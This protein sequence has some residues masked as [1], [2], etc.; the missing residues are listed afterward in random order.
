MRR[1]CGGSI[2][3]AASG[4][5]MGTA[6]MVALDDTRVPPTLYNTAVCLA[7][8]ALGSA[9]PN[10]DPR[11]GD[12]HA[13]DRALSRPQTIESLNLIVRR[14]LSMR[15]PVKMHEMRPKYSAGC[16]DNSADC[17]SLAPF[18]SLGR[19]PVLIMLCLHSAPHFTEKFRRVLYSEV[20]QLLISSVVLC[21]AFL[22]LR[23]YLAPI[24][25]CCGF[26]EPASEN[27]FARLLGCR[28]CWKGSRAM[29]I[30]TSR[31]ARCGTSALSWWSRTWNSAWRP[32]A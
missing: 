3:V 8:V 17:S 32:N 13:I 10:P 15:L 16:L 7:Q 1:N 26:W 31:S 19:S 12:P 18:C 27:L 2:R 28:K 22:S 6:D 21:F 24:A 5:D 20:A 11:K 23:Y 4:Q 25:G 30:W 14:L 29:S 9:N